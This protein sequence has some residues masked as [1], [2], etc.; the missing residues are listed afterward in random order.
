MKSARQTKP[1]AILAGR[2]KRAQGNS[3]SPGPQTVDGENQPPLA[4]SP[5]PSSGV[6]PTYEELL[7]VFG[8][9]PGMLCIA[10]FD[11]KFKRLN[12]PWH[13]AMGWSPEELQTR[14]FLDWSRCRELIATRELAQRKCLEEEILNALDH[15]RE[16]VG[17]ELH[18]GLCQNLAAIAAL[19][20]T[21]ARRLAPAALAEAAAV[22]EI[23]KL[24]HQSIRHAHDLARGFIPLHLKGIGLVEALAEFCL[25]TEA[26]FKIACGF[27]CRHCSQELDGTLKSHL[28]RIAQ[29]AVN[30]AIAH[31]HARWIEVS[32]TFANGQGTLAIQDDGIGLGDQ[33]DRHEGIGLHTMAYRARQIGASFTLQ[34]RSPDGTIATCVFPLP[35]AAPKSSPCARKQNQTHPAAKNPDSP[36]R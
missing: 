6:L 21:V 18:D 13:P 33:F 31:G 34:P 32:L 25:N 3:K 22:R 2:A 4:G 27:R 14:P 5:P 30:N 24:L 15:E 11:G 20:A 8:E 16:R 9:S 36:R 19:S 17:R 7:R 10:D 26:L 12:P 28:Y 23:G 1:P 35:P 29:E